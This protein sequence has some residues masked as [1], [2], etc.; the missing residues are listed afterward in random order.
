MFHVKNH[1]QRN[2]FD[3]WA[4][5]G[6]KRR[7]VLENSWAGLFQQ[8]ILPKSPVETLRSH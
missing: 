7:K 8:K 2:I 3:P 1:R 5:S 4:Q 6:A